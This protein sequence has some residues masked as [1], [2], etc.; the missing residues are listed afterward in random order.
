M[1]DNT[2]L[3]DK[4]VEKVGKFS[5]RHRWNGEL[6]LEKGKKM[7]IHHQTAFRKKQKKTGRFKN[8]IIQVEENI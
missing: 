1:K 7:K 5:F 3:D 4:Q 2:N 6:F 8:S